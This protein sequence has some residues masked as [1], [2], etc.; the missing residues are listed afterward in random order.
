MAKM[1]SVSI[2]TLRRWDSTKRLVAK[3]RPSG[4]RYYT[5]EQYL[6]VSGKN[7]YKR[8][9]EDLDAIKGKTVLITGGSGSLGNALV[10]RLC[11]YCKKIIIFSRCEL[12]QANMCNKFKEYNNIRY[13]LGDIKDK[14]RLLFAL[15][16]V[17]ICIHAACY[18]RIDSCSYNPFEAVKTNVVG[19]MNVAEACV[20]SGIPKVVMISTD[21]STSAATLYGG[22]KFVSEQ[23][24]I[25]GN[26]YSSGTT[27]FT[28]VRYGN[29]FGS[30]G[31][32]KHIFDKQKEENGEISITHEEMTRFFMSLND[33]VNLILYTLNNCI[34]GEIFIPKMKSIKIM[35]F[36]NILYPNVPKK[37]IGLRGHEKIHE[38]LISETES[39]Y[40]VDCG[41][42]YKIIPPNVNVPGIGWDFN[43]PVEPLMKPF[44][45]TSD[46]V[47]T[48]SVEELK[49]FESTF[50]LDS[51][52]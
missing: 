13:M 12:K 52:E 18:K 5:H 41:E 26:N 48:L 2:D 23:M 40:V 33:A 37:I 3:R 45:Y 39:R 10:K 9:G 20:E 15:S 8:T 21:K 16:N 35:D 44:K 24:F 50:G 28:C 22:T 6:E 1:L 31:S 47:E 14:N 51:I 30:N 29:I 11:D 42:Y 19:S 34:G 4:H 17:D 25:N 32:I 46:S 27:I 49:N 43:Y 7:K 38:E 36:V